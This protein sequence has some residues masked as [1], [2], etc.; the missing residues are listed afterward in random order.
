MH[1]GSYGNWI[2]PTHAARVFQYVDNTFVLDTVAQTIAMFQALPSARV[3]PSGGLTAARRENWDINFDR[4]GA[5]TN[6]YSGRVNQAAA[7]IIIE[8][9]TLDSWI[10]TRD[11]R[12]TLV[13]AN[14][15][16]LDTVK[17]SG[18]NVY[19]TRSMLRVDG[20][21]FASTDSRV[22][23][24]TIFWNRSVDSTNGQN[25]V[26]PE[27]SYNSTPNLFPN[28]MTSMKTAPATSTTDVPA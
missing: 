10:I 4:V 24:G 27:G 18:V 7:P 17:I 15:V 3:T 8:S 2:N 19:N 11:T 16:P 12:F 9:L 13:D 6:L 21:S 1:V 20:T 22:G 23:F 25:T 26:G 14:R 28:C 5:V